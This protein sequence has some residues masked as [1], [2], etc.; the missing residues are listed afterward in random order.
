[1][2]SYVTKVW[3]TRPSLTI[4]GWVKLKKS[5]ASRPCFYC[6]GST[7]TQRNISI[8]KMNLQLTRWLLGS[9]SGSWDLS[10]VP[11][12]SSSGPKHCDRRHG[13]FGSE[14]GRNEAMVSQVHSVSETRED[15]RSHSSSG[16][17]VTESAVELD[18]T[19]S[20]NFCKIYLWGKKKK[21]NTS[22]KGG[23]KQ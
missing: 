7:N 9:L 10:R 23:R 4:T 18:V 15:S 19:R 20:V 13:Q 14:G 16:L 3:I 22:N 11:E 8:Y 5:P 21:I 1:M 12:R 2:R 6:V 17:E